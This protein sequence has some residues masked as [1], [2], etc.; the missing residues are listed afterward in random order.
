MSSTKPPK[1]M[2]KDEAE[3]DGGD[4]TWF[5]GIAFLFYSC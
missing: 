2:R 3:D 4:V 1:R 5:L